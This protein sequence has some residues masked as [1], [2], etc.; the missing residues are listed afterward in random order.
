[1]SRSTFSMASKDCC[2]STLS[3]F[4]ALTKC[5]NSS[6]LLEIE[7][8]YFFH[9][10]K[11]KTF[12]KIL[13]FWNKMLQTTIILCFEKTATLIYLHLKPGIKEYKTEKLFFH[14]VH[15]LCLFVCFAWVCLLFLQNSILKKVSLLMDWTGL[16]TTLISNFCY[17]H[18]QHKDEVYC[19][20]YILILPLLSV[21]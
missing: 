7:R 13:P 2:R 21:W 4:S 9:A 10:A 11:I 17:W 1:M 14:L 18:F 20:V 15:T 3:L 5:H 16:L 12:K 19:F 6:L 8:K